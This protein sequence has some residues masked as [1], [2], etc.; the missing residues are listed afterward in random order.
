M[1]LIFVTMSMHS[2]SFPCWSNCLACWIICM[3]WLALWLWAV[4]L[5][6][7][8]CPSEEEEVGAVVPVVVGLASAGP[9]PS[10]F[11]VIDFSRSARRCVHGPAIPEVART[12]ANVVPRTVR[13]SMTISSA[14]SPH[15]Y[16]PDLCPFLALNG[17]LL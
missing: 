16:P 15:G 14:Q 10:C 1:G 11:A 2:A 8:G 7:D 4:T 6:P 13:V 17:Q 12:S 3:A 9:A 5:V